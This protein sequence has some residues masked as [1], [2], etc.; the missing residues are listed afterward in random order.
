MLFNKQ[1]IVLLVDDEPG[2]RETAAMILEGWDFIVHEA[3]DG[4]SAVSYMRENRPDLILLDINLPDI[5]GYDICRSFKNN[6]AT[7]K[8]PIILFTGLGKTKEVDKGFLCGADDYL[9]KPVDM[10]RLKFKI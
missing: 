3:E 9:I 1:K 4:R 8:I 6:H 5:N 10:E 7:K 2:I